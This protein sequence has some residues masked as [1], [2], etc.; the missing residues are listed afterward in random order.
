MNTYVPPEG[1]LEHLTD[2]LG[3]QGVQTAPD[4]LAP[5]LREW[6][7]RYQGA[8]AAV[9]R[10]DST[11]AVSAAVKL[12]TEAGCPMTPQGG[13]TG[14]VGGAVAEGGVVLSLERMNRIRNMDAAAYTITVEAGCVLADVQAAARGAGRLFPL[15]LGAEGTCQVGGNLSTNAGGVHVLRYGNARDLAL[16]LEVVLPGGRVW[17]GLR[18]LRKDNTGYALKHL[19][20][21]AEGTLGV[22]TAAVLKLFPRP[23]HVETAFCAL[24]D[25][26]AAIALFRRCM[27]GAGDVL[28]AFEVSNRTG[29]ALAESL[30]DDITTP[31]AEASPFYALIEFAA[32]GE[33]GGGEGGGLREVFESVLGAAMEAGEVTDAAVAE[34][35]AQA[36]GL[37]R[38]REGI[39]QA[40]IPAGLC[41]KHDVSVPIS[42]IPEFLKRAEAAALAVEPGARIVA[43]GHFGD[44]NIHFNAVRPEAA[45]D[46]SFRPLIP[47]VQRAVHDIAADM[48]GSFSAEHGIGLSKRGELAL[49]RSAAETDMMRA[50]K[51][52][53][54]PKGLM[55]PGKILEP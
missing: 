38:I 23:A 15:S 2:A 18:A 55:N 27:E 24:P 46:E 48:G 33:G 16:G 32:S 12:C 1:L 28:N 19:F 25:A 17:D 8:A 43:Y 4:D 31:L 44:G 3:P 11:K 40:Q 30:L 51:A 5:Y 36:A 37:W 34:T 7:G 49:Y 54:D 39:T 50:L 45:D 13:N 47:A 26:D 14:L 41:A 6:R 22:I 10:P 20:I 29:V 21:G 9:L 52:A 53:F 35:K 42:A